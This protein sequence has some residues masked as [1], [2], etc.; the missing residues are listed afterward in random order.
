MS[1]A[2][3]T[4][5]ET[6]QKQEISPLIMAAHVITVLDINFLEIKYRFITPV[7]IWHY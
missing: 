6:I 2:Q 4:L 7:L 3:F 5:I 1:P